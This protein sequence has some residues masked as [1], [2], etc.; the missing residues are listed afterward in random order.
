[1]KLRDITER[2]CSVSLFAGCFLGLL[3]DP[4]SE[5]VEQ[6]FILDTDY[7]VSSKSFGQAGRTDGPPNNTLVL[8]YKACNNINML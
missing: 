5:F 1:M 6:I 8:C 4:I 3:F 7:Q 2:D